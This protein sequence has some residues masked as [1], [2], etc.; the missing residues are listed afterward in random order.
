MLLIGGVMGRLR[1][2]AAMTLAVAV[3]VGGV[4]L[5]SLTGPAPAR[6][7][8]AR[9]AS[10]VD[11]QRAAAATRSAVCTSARHPKLAARI[12]RGITAALADRKDSVV[13]LAATDAA[14]DLHCTLRQGLHFYAA[15]VIKVTIISAL[16]LKKGGPA[17]LTTAQHNLAYAM[18]TQS[19]DNAATTLWDETGTAAMRRFLDKARMSH[20]ILNA[21]WGLTQITAQDELTL[22]KLLSVKGTV[23]SNS[24]RGYVLWLMSKVTASQRWGTPAGVPSSLTVH[25]KNGWLPYPKADDWH[26]NSLGIFTGKDTDYQIVVLTGP[27]AAGG[28]GESYGI[29]TV[30]DAARVINRD[31][32]HA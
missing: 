10:S 9:S 3:G 21:A 25:V 4:A 17:H 1:Y 31:L 32:A 16:L 26:I 7:A 2:Q 20:T 30:Q 6:A 5:A 29:T 8:T 23:L 27:P 12:A 18:I 14:E 28:Q 19:N 11:T 22:L 24:S 13:G 15:S